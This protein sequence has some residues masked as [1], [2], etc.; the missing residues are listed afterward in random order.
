MQ[1]N[2]NNIAGGIE[3]GHATL[4]QFADVFFLE[5]QVPGINR[6]VR[7]ENRPDL[8][9]VITNARGAPQIR[10]RIAVAGVIVLHLRQDGRIKVWQ[11]G[12]LR[13]VQRLQHPGFYQVGQHIV[14]GN[15]HVV[16]AAPHHEFALHDIAAV[17][18]VI[19]R[20]DAG[21]GLEILHRIRGDKVVPVVHMH[22]G[23]SRLHLGQPHTQ[24]SR[25]GPFNA[26]LGLHPATP[27]NSSRPPSAWLICS[28][29][30]NRRRSWR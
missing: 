21:L 9:R 8:V 20:S 4:A 24:Q 10:H 18:Y 13:A 5:D 3:H 6:S 25:Q 14:A 26:A 17:E 30:S 7:S 29:A 22:P 27:V 19:H 23:I 28:P 15:H 16:T 12:Q 1:G 2:G 11:V